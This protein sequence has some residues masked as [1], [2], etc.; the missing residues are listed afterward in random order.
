M[1][2]S[3]QS[4]DSKAVAEKVLKELFAYTKY[5]FGHEEEIM[6]KLGYPEVD[7][8]KRQ[9]TGFVA[10]VNEMQEGVADGDYSLASIAEFVK[11]WI[12]NH[13]MVTDKRLGAFLKDKLP[14]TGEFDF[15]APVIGVVP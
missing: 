10:K 6:T 13:I 1:V 15:D 4:T 3:L 7:E 12:L 14:A 5:H 2:E 11:K 8:H 9:H